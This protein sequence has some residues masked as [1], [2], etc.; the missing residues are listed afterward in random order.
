VGC[1]AEI[2]EN[3]CLLVSCSSLIPTPPGLWHF[4]KG[5]DSGKTPAPS[6]RFRFPVLRVPWRGRASAA[7]DVCDQPTVFSSSRRIRRKVVSSRGTTAPRLVFE[8]SYSLC[9]LQAATSQR[10]QDSKLRPQ[11]PSMLNA[12]R[13]LWAPSRH[14]CRLLFR[15][16]ENAASEVANTKLCEVWRS[17]S[18]G[19]SSL[20]SS[21]A[22]SGTG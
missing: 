16:L 8:K 14:R 15:T 11:G 20:Y 1:S 21:F 13:L 18:Y 5:K 17:R 7:E 2:G 3:G 10:E 6:G 22:I 4:Q 9:I 19:T 12:Q